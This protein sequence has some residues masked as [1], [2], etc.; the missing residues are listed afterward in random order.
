MVRWLLLHKQMPVRI[1]ILRISF[2]YSVNVL[3]PI[4]KLAQLPNVSKRPRKITE[5]QEAKYLQLNWKRRCVTFP[6]KKMVNKL[7]TMIQMTKY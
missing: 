1:L 3:L 6:V 5:K 2:P 7:V 4:S